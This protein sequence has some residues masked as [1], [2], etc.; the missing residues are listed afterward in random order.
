VNN[1]PMEESNEPLVDLFRV[2]EDALTIASSNSQSELGLSLD[3]AE[4]E[5]NLST[6][7]EV[8][9]G[10][11][12]KAIGLNASAK[13]ESE[14]THQYKLKLR[15]SQEEFKLG[16]PSANEL[17]ETILAL[18]RASCSITARAKNYSLDE[19]VVTVDIQ[20]TKEG[21]LHVLAGGGGGT[22]DVYRITLTFTNRQR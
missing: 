12:I 4:L 11:E 8:G 15:R 6:K 13:G 20:R 17:A 22:G 14:S 10:V 9:G 2:V 1:K 16:P 5:L 18:A 7:K 21:E 3:T 19:A